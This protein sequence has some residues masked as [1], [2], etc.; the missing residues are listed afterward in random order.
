VR[1]LAGRA[2]S[3]MADCCSSKA[4]GSGYERRADRSN[5]QIRAMGVFFG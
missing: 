1:R 5:E 3:P 2:G 4:V